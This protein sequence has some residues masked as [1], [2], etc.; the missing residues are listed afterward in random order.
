LKGVDYSLFEGIIPVFAWADW[1]RPPET[2]VTDDM[3]GLEPASFGIQVWN[4][5]ATRPF[6]D[7]E[8]WTIKWK[9][10]VHQ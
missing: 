9:M 6:S 4:I 7:I 8:A 1:E 10:Y 5:A 3:T 2:E